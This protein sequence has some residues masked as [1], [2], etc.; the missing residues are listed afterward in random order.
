MLGA[1]NYNTTGAEMSIMGK[2]IFYNE[3]L[4]PIDKL[5]RG[6]SLKSLRLLTQIAT[7]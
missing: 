2:F 5:E 7:Q 4:H 1:N 6:I 3:K